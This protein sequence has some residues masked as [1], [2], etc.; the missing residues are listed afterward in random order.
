[1]APVTT[2]ASTTIVP[3]NTNCCPAS[4]VMFRSVPAVDEMVLR[5]M[6]TLSTWR[7]VKVPTDVRDDAVTPAARV[8]PESVPAAA[9]TVIGAVPSKFTPFIALGVCK[10]VA[11]AALP[12]R[13]PTNDVPVI[14]PPPVILLPLIAKSPPNV[15]VPVIVKSL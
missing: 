10:A 2:P 9:V 7:A 11:V 3:S 12:V 5:F 6:F 1:M 13:G 14:V 4:G 8:A 15:V